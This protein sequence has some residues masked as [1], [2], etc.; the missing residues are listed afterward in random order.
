MRYCNHCKVYIKDNTN[1]CIL[2]GNTLPIE[3]KQNIESPTF[4][5][6]P[7]FYESHMPI[8]ILSFI[9]ISAIVISF[10][11]NMI[12]RSD[13]N[14]PLL[15]MLGLVSVWIGLY[16]IIKKRYHIPKKIITQVIIISLLSVFWDWKT[17]WRGWSTTYVIPIIIVSAMIIMY[18]TA[19]VLKL[20]TRDYIT[21][22]LIAGILG[23][24][25]VIFILFH[26]VSIIYPSIISISVSIISISAIFI[27]KGDEI[28]LELDKRM[29]I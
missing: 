20:S 12:F 4:P 21:Y 9:S 13:V 10:A 24:V 25:P 14:W 7:L 5:Y 8:K 23:I 18:I 27:F 16:V 29:H 3:Y 11:I 26:W 19:K 15:V 2:C 28:R 1:K 22:F 6:I 17:G